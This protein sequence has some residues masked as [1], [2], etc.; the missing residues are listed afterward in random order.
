[1][2]YESQG[3][4][5]YWSTTTVYSSA[6][7]A[8]VGQVVGFSGPSQSANVIDVTHLLS[9][10]KEKLIGVYDGGQITINLNWAASDA[11]QKKLQECLRART[12]GS[13]F[14]ELTGTVATGKSISAEGYVTGLN[15]TG[16]VDNKVA[17][18]VTIAIT[19]GVSLST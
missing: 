7:S 9:T 19:G 1:M 14:I 6:D 11:A 12:K 8:R 2:A 16:S 5:F 18:D 15:I 10:A 13:F 3:I 4:P 17:G